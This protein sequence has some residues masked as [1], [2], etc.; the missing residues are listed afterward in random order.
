MIWENNVEAYILHKQLFT[1]FFL[2]FKI[3][4][5][6]LR[7]KKNIFSKFHNLGL[8]WGIPQIV[9]VCSHVCMPVCARLCMRM[10]MGTCVHTCLCTPAYACH[11]ARRACICALACACSRTCAR[12]RV[13]VCAWCAWCAC[14][15]VLTIF[16]H[17]LIK[18]V[19]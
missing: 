4:L 7:G 11:P 17:V 18:Q 5:S 12:V 15:S 10:Y 16:I 19:G 9:C 3:H 13:R 1:Y 2:L 6:G 14:V 8:K